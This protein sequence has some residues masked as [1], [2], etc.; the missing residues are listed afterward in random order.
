MPVTAAP[1]GSAAETGAR[2][3]KKAHGRGH[4][5]ALPKPNLNRA[6][7]HRRVLDQRSLTISASP[8]KANLKVPLSIAKS[9][10]LLGDRLGKGRPVRF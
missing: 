3:L 6:S 8:L 1:A 2:E 10:R 5:A 4:S 9:D 7:D